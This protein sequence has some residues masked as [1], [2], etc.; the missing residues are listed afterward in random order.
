LAEVYKKSVSKKSSLVSNSHKNRLSFTY[1][2]K[3]SL[4]YKFLANT[5]TLILERR[6]N[7]WL[8]AIRNQ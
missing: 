1:K 4:T 3:K 6:T 8:K 7:F 5:I 2:L